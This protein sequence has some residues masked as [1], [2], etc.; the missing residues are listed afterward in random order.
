L[1]VQL[2]VREISDLHSPEGKIRAKLD[3]SAPEHITPPAAT[4]R[5]KTTP[6][7]GNNTAFGTNACLN[8]LTGSNVTCIG[9]NAG[10][11]GDIAG[12]ATYI[13]N[14]YGAPTTGSGNPLVCIDSTGLLGITNCAT[15]GAPSA[16]NEM[17]ERQQEQIE[18]LQKQNEDLQQRLARLEAL[19]AKN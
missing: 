14:V 17:I 7:G 15:N 9:A 4:L 18:T 2:I 12:P 11:S 8:L 13:A 6:R 16:Q 10:P 5:S 1:L 3:S 19:I